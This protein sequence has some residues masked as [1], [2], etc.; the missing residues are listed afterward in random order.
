MTEDEAKLLNTV[1]RHEFQDALAK[2]GLVR[3]P[4]P[5]G[6]SPGHG[7]GLAGSRHNP[8]RV[9][10]Q[11]SPGH[12][13]TFTVRLTTEM[14]IPAGLISIAAARDAPATLTA[15]P[16]GISE[17]VPATSSRAPHRRPAQQ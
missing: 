10:P 13:T 12:D 8:R 16:T 14:G 6:T 17:R 5:S 9:T 1:R 7:K 15:R 4:R 11:P 2:L 3:R